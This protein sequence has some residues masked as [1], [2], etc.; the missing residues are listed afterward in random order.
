MMWGANLLEII[1]II[2]EMESRKITGKL[3]KKRVTCIHCGKTW[4]EI[5]GMIIAHKEGREDMY[6]RIGMES[7]NCFSCRWRA[8]KCEECNSTDVYE[9]TF[10]KKIAEETSLS[11]KTIKQVTNRSVHTDS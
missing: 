11:F 6:L 2:K 9:V 7:E 1:E 4:I 5:V 3:S 8:L 10:P